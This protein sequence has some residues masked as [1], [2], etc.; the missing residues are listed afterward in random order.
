[1]VE[2]DSAYLI[3]R[4]E[5]ELEQAKR[6]TTAK[7]AQVHSALAQTYL[8]RLNPDMRASIEQRT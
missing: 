6:A 1:M 7:V 3:Q 8:E 4:A 5:A 2:D